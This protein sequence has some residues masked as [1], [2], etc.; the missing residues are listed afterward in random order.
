MFE[1][2]GQ[3]SLSDTGFEP[4]PLV[5]FEPAHFAS[6]SITVICLLQQVSKKDNKYSSVCKTQILWNKGVEY[7]LIVTECGQQ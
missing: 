3:K 2:G 1:T 6:G 5:G 7:R 4:F